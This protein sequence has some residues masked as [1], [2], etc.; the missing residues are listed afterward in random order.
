MISRFLNIG[1][2]NGSEYQGEE[3]RN[4]SFRVKEANNTMIS[5]SCIFKHVRKHRS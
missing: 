5:G 1:I 4:F 2:V 3:G